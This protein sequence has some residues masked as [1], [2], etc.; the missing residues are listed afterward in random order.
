MV[1]QFKDGDIVK[2]KPEWT[3]SEEEKFTL[4]V[5]TIDSIDEQ[6]GRC[7][8]RPITGDSS[9]LPIV[10]TERVALEMLIPTTFN[11]KDYTNN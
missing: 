11:F 3:N 7:N 6:T 4:Y 2:I 9:K 10:P 5:I 8:I 1:Q